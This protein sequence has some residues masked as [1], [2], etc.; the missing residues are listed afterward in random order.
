MVT[1]PES[2]QQREQ[3]VQDRIDYLTREIDRL[4]ERRNQLSKDLKEI[5]NEAVQSVQEADS[6]AKR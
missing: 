6:S 1:V 2:P 5:K 3:R 4:T